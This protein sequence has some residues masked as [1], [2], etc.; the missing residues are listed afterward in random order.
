MR[1]AQIVPSGNLPGH[2]V[3]WITYKCN[4]TPYKDSSIKRYEP[5]TSG[6]TIKTR[7]HLV[8]SLPK[9][10]S[11]EWWPWLFLWVAHWLYL[12]ASHWQSYQKERDN[13]TN[14]IPITT[15]TTTTDNRRNMETIIDTDIS[16]FQKNYEEKW[17]EEETLKGLKKKTKNSR[18]R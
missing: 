10:K 13:M 12:W 18:A 17:T 4:R 5:K 14:T 7:D 2:L 15:T 6:S 8:T 11:Y 3:R 1:N 9:A 16:S